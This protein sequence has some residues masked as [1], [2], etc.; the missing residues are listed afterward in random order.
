[1]DS[2]L[3]SVFSGSGNPLVR[4]QGFWLFEGANEQLFLDRYAFKWEFVPF[5]LG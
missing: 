1:M 2:C 5:R 4:N 3:A